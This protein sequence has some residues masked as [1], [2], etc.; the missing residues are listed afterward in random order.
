MG[1][2]HWILGFEVKRNREKRTISL[3]QTAYIRAT[4]V[5][6][7]FE[8]IKP[9]ATPMDTNL[10]LSTNDAPQTVQDFAYMRDKPYRKAVGSLQYASV[11]TRLDITNVCSTLSCYL[12]KPGPVHWNAVKHVFGY[13]AGTADLALT[14]GREEKD[15][16]GYA[17]AD[18]LMNEDRKAVSGYAFLI[19][20]GA[21]SW[22]TKKQEI[23]ALSTTE[24]EY[25]AVTHAAKEALWLRTLI[26]EIFGDINGPTTLYSD[27]QSAIALM[28]DHQ[29]HMRTKH[30]DIRFHFIRWVI[31]EGKIKLVYCPTNDMLAD[32]FTKALPSVKVKH[33]ATALGLFRD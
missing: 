19:N 4:L 17:D 5:K 9:Y 14:F 27:N 29:H 10:K 24:A 32:S 28:K 31:E 11:G 26:K 33:F 30:I 2:I 15:L 22:C 13:L 6:Y 3:S 21:V 12:E 18:G 25:V 16:E 8:N 23:I 20:G 7:G 1:E